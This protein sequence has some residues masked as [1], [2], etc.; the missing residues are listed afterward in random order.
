M[1]D[2]KLLKDIVFSNND[3]I[4]KW[5]F[6]DICDGKAR[7]FYKEIPNSSGFDFFCAEW[8]A[9]DADGKDWDES[10]TYVECLYSGTCLYDGVRHLYMGDSQTDN[11]GYHYYPSLT[12]HLS[13]FKALS[14]LE[15][16]YKTI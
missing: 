9:L 8:A 14:E 4:Y 10:F 6:I 5:S 13:F 3:Y 11:Y 16:K 2:F 12:V 7:L 15:E 1:D